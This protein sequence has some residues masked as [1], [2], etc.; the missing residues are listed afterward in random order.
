[1]SWELVPSPT[2]GGL[3]V[4]DEA[5]SES[6]MQA[7]MVGVRDVALT[8]MEQVLQEAGMCLPPSLHVLCAD[9]DPPLAAWVGSRPMRRGA[10]AADA[11][12]GLGLLPA[13]MWATHV[14][15]AW[16][17]SDLLAA[18]GE[19]GGAEPAAVVVTASMTGH[20]VHWHPYE[21][22]V[23]RTT[24]TGL[25]SVAPVWGEPQQFP[26]GG[27]PAP[28]ARLLA[29]WRDWRSAPPVEAAAARMLG[30]GYRVRWVER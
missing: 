27:L 4:M 30:D 6:M 28:V 1:M 15:I 23:G 16:D 7:V 5:G 10:D 29:T 14:V 22:R 20:V 21:Q 26:G 24:A 11:V 18:L 17:H 25:P 12:A 13:A 19:E 2:R 3:T 8:T 9:L